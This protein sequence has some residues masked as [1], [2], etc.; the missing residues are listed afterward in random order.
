[1]VLFS[2]CFYR[3]SGN[4]SKAD[5]Y[6]EKNSA[7]SLK[8]E[9]EMID[10]EVMTNYDSLALTNKENNII[11]ICKRKFTLT[12]FYDTVKIKEYIV[13]LGKNPNDKKKAGDNATPL[14]YFRIIKIENSSYWTHDFNDGKGEIRGAYG[15]YFLLL[16]TGKEETISGKEWKEI[17]IHGTHNEE[18]IGTNASEG[19]VR[20]KNEELID[21]MRFVSIDTKVEIRE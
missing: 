12:L 6:N 13:A 17:G 7:D 2:S 8:E 1:M 10:E 4:D 9:S 18:S 19:C 3:T 21:L 14:G 16:K 11:V 20:M 5:L 15:P